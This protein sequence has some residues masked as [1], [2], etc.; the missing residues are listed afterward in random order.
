M[1]VGMWE[2]GNAR[3][4]LVG[5]QTDAATMQFSV[6]NLQKAENKNHYMAQ[7][8][9]ESSIYI[10]IQEFIQGNGLLLALNI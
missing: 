9:P 5:V 8:V 10:V 3:S 2:K 7:L 4:L 1:L 6:E